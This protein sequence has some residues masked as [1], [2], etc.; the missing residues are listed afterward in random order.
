M[1]ILHVNKFLHR[2]GGAE[3]Y[4]L[5]LAGLQRTAGHETA[6]FGMEHPDNDQPSAGR[7]APYVEFEPAPSG[8]RDKLALL[9]R[10]VWSTAARDG[11][12][13][14]LAEFRPDVVHAHNIYHQLSPSVLHA[15][16]RRGVPVVLTMHDY[17]LVCPTYQFLDHGKICTACVEGGPWQAAR[18]SCKDGQWAASTAAALEVSLHRRFGAYDGV[19]CFVAPSRFLAAQVIAGG[20]DADRV[21]VQPNFTETDLPWGAE[22]NR[23]AVFAGRLSREK[24]VD[25]LVRAV[26]RLA[27]LPS[28]ASLTRQAPDGVLLDIVGDG[29]ERTALEA[30]ADDVAPGRVRFHGRVGR[31]TLQALVGSATLSVV[32][33]RWLENQPLAV[34][35]SFALGVPVLTTDL[36]GLPELVDDSTG[37]V[38]SADDD[39]AMAAVLQ[40]ALADPVGARALGAQ[41]R[42]RVEE[43][44]DP[45]SHAEAITDIYRKAGAAT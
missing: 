8:V 24:G 28:R 38:V 26:G 43:R 5:D 20:L 25:T 39:E 2:R 13:Q 3:G 14:A 27:A 22:P 30:L 18:R 19:G 29:P 42:R 9:G 33:S 11:M 10:M 23:A 17:K 21:V 40:G 6:Y 34:L 31:T 37:W 12:E 15:A 35:E 36:G 7:P 1:R 45:K 16:A 4:L 41:G 44:H 32:P